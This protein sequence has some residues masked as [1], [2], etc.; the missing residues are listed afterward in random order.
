MSITRL[1]TAN[2]YDRTISNISKQQ[3]ELAQPDG[4][5]HGRQARAAR[6]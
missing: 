2:M 1:G 3:A 6:Q 5:H 4:T